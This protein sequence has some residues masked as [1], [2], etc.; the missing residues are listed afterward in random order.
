MF[1]SA[2]RILG[3]L[4]TDGSSTHDN[5]FFLLSG[6]TYGAGLWSIR[7]CTRPALCQMQ[8]GRKSVCTV[9]YRCMTLRTPPTSLTSR[10][11]AN[12]ISGA[13][14]FIS[15]IYKQIFILY[16]QHSC[17]RL[18]TKYEQQGRNENATNRWRRSNDCAVYVQKR[19]FRNQINAKAMLEMLPCVRAP[20]PC[21]LLCPALRCSPPWRNE[22]LQSRTYH[23]RSLPSK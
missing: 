1:G 23:W 4:P 14:C 21:T 17:T 10:W 20:N 15:T 6:F 13:E 12:A 3:W 5:V 11:W 16:A 19:G 22:C 8:C 18:P 2:L 7:F 9:L